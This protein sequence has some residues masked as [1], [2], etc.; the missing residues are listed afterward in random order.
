MK[1]SLISEFREAVMNLGTAKDLATGEVTLAVSVSDKRHRAATQ[2]IHG[3]SLESA[4]SKVTTELAPVPQHSWVRVEAITGIQR[5]PLSDFQQDLKK[6]MRMNFWRRGISFDP[7]FKTALLEMEINGH[8]FFHPSDQH[9][10]GK[11]ATESWIDFEA[12]AQYLTERNG[13]SCA[14]LADSRYIWSFS[15]IGIFSDGQNIWP[16]S[17]REDGTTG[18]RQL[19]QPKQ[20][21]EN[22]LT[23]A[24]AYLTRQIKDEGKFI[25]GYFPATQ[26]VLTNY[27]SVRHFSSIYALLEAIAYTGKV[28]DLN[29]VKLALQWGI[30]KLTIAKDH[31][32]FAIE[33]PKKGTPEIKLGAQAMLI[34][35]LCKYQEVTQDDQFADVALQACRGVDVFRQ[36]SGKFN[37]VLNPDLSVKDSFRVIY[38]EGEIAFALI[39]LF[40]STNEES[41]RQQ[42]QQTLDF[43]VQNDFGKYHDHWIAYA[44][45]EAAQIFPDNRDYMAMGL[46]NAFS[47]LDFIEKQVSPHPTRLE[48]LD[49]T[50]RL[51]DTIRRT[52]NDDLLEKY[53]SQHL[54]EVWQQRAE[55][56][57]M[58]G[59]FEPEVAMFF[60][61]PSKFYGGFFTRN[62]HFRTRI[63]DCEHFLSGLI[64]YI[65]YK[66]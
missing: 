60:Y 41:I 38:Y 6:M 20:E 39:R 43:M 63:D 62:D 54:R 65:N 58:V 49:A 27:N 42:A 35:A 50:V 48:L 15:T 14:N 59:A 64:N 45:N 9:V 25:Y 17:D 37:H 29:R 56:E 5:R 16:L 1:K 28:E 24:E 32:R 40:E 52:G 53:D 11:N 57:L 19:R 18:V 26:R 3:N 51:I 31:A 46:Q 7:E 4:W 33:Y 22:Y 13:E 12:I 61:K 30:D 2:F 21:I 55:F 47:N 36:P 66:Y 44:A 10:I 8:E 34:L 23:V